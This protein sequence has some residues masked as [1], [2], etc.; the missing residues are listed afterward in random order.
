MY[1]TEKFV[2]LIDGIDDYSYGSEVVNLI[3]RFVLPLHL[4]ID[5]VKM[6]GSAENFPF[7]VRFFKYFL[8]FVYDEID[9]FL[10][11]AYLR[12]DIDRQKFVSLGVEI[13]KAKVFEFAFYLRNTEP[14]RDRRIDIERFL[15]HAK[16]PLLGKK[17]KRTH[18]V[19]TIG[20]FDDDDADILCHRHENFLEVFRL[21]LFMGLEFDFIELCNPLDKL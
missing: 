8:D 3:E 14:A 16:L 18:I 20:K 11:F 19:Q 6:L 17:V 5:A 12:I 10:S 4:F 1:F 7:Y 15:C 13:F 2:T 21:L 9:E